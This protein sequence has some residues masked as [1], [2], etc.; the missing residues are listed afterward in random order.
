MVKDLEVLE[1]RG[2]TGLGALVWGVATEAVLE[3]GE[4]VPGRAGGRR[5]RAGRL[6]GGLVL[7]EPDHGSADGRDLRRRRPPDGQNLGTPMTILLPL[8]LLSA[9]VALALL[10]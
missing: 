7:P 5:R 3:Q 1:A 6:L 2:L 10:R 4:R 9:L 8:A